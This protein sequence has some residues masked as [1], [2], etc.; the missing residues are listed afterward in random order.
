MVS[1]CFKH[2]CLESY[3]AYFPETEVS[4]AEIEAQLAP[5]YERLRLPIGTLEMLSGVRTRYLW[6]KTVRASQVATV[7]AE[8]A[9]ADMGFDRS[10]LRALINCSVTRDFFEPATACLVHRNLKLP[11]DAVT[12]DISNACVGFSNGVT[13]LASMIDAGVVPAG[14]VVSG[15]NVS[16]LVDS[17][18]AEIASKPALTRRE[19]QKLLPSLTLGSGA[20]A[21]V[22]CHENIASRGHRVIGSVSR[23]ATQY[24]D[25]C[26]GNGDYAQVIDT[27]PLMHT[28]PLA[29]VA[30]GKEQGARAWRDA[31]EKFGWTR[32]DVDH[33]FGHQIG[34]QVNEEFYSAIGLDIAREYTIYGR[35][36]NLVSAAL[37]ATFVLGVKERKVK[38]GERIL[39]MAFGSG[40]NV[41]F[42]GITW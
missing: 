8:R 17:V 6:D 42:T 23:S 35:Y 33:I 29:L 22:L 5:I 20:V 16:A 30:A 31:S 37:P 32:E 9:I 40:V 1:F 21:F 13:T 12:F 28:E 19:L 2:V 14:L 27:L 4:S 26:R 38:R 39:L 15:E 34:K 24:S 18:I 3:A 36:G 7:A 41:I 10:Q 25:L 11:E